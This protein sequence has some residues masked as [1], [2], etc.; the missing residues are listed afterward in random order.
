MEMDVYMS[1]LRFVHIGGAVLWAGSVFMAAL[2]II[3]ATQAMGPEGGKFMRT[4]F[5]TNKYPLVINGTA[6]LSVLSGLILFDK[7]SNHFSSD[8]LHS[9]YGVML[10]VGSLIGLVAL[11]YGS[12]ILRPTAMKLV[13]L[14]DEV[15]A[16]GA[17]PS[18]E[19][20]AELEKHS[21]TMRSGMR[22]MAILLIVSVFAMSVARYTY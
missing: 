18:P 4:L 10:S 1:I 13:R 17:P 16:G 5:K 15:E 19:Q 14:G 22:L 11:I 8:W 3:P 12:I 20:Q 7:I 21:G 9:G 2:F 6:A